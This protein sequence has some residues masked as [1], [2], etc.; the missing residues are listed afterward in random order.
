M[1]QKPGMYETIGEAIVGLVPIV[2]GVSVVGWIV[3]AVLT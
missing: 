1:D 3:Y 2:F